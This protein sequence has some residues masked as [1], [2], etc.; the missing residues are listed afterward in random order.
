MNKT[1]T[2]LHIRLYVIS[3]IILAIGLC[4][5]LLIYLTAEDDSASAASYVVVD[6][7]IYPIDPGSSKLY[8]RELQRFGGKAAVLFDEFG[9]WFAGLWHGRSLAI[10]VAWMSILVSLGVFLFAR[11]LASDANSDE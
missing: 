9:R 6:G 11:H 2:R 5:A 4:C 10:T 1:T 3:G 8:V 7:V